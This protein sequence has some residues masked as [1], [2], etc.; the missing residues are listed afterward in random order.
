V[1]RKKEMLSEVRR[2]P[3]KFISFSETQKKF[4]S[5]FTEQVL[6]PVP[7]TIGITFLQR[8]VKLK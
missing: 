6:A 4:S 5:Y 7:I 1:K 8:K 2:L 3:D